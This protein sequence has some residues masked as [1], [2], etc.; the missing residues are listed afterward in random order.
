MKRISTIVLVFSVLVGFIACEDNGQFTEEQ[1][2]KVIYL[3]SSDNNKV[4]PG[5]HR[6]DEAVS[7]GYVSIGVG[8]TNPIDQNVTVEI[9]RD[10]SL[11]HVYNKIN[12]DIDSSKYAR[13]LDPARFDIQ[14]YQITLKAGNQDQ[15]TLLPIRVHTTG[16]SP[17]SIYF[18]P[19]RIKSVS[20]YEVNPK[21]QAV[22][23]RVYLEN[24]YAQQKEQTVYAVRGDRQVG[25]GGPSKVTLDKRAYPVTKDQ[26]RIFADTKN[27][28]DKLNE[29]N[30]YSI[31]LQVKE[32]STIN[33]TSYRPDLLEVQQI[34]ENEG[35]NSI[36]RDVLGVNRIY[37][38][39]KFR[40]RANAAEEFDTWTRM[41][42]NLR[43]V[44]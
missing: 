26:I 20:N 9:E 21:Y 22:L 19:L 23:Y 28:S 6:L 25:D 11:M 35:D 15:Y 12:F 36:H 1:Y 16:L 30:R 33:I 32:D 39:Y 44:E 24:D 7:T 29:I 42:I 3:L 31:L 4:F 5:I 27:S 37:L 14:S 18:V 43:R 13:E 40:T 8:G 34:S 38:H 2:K 10:D 41:D 17:D